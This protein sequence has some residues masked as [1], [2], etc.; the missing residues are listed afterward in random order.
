MFKSD[1]LTINSFT[2]TV[3]T[4]IALNKT[5]YL[6]G[7]DISITCDVTGSPAPE[8]RWYKNDERLVSDERIKVGGKYT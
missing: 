4:N 2:V 6:A 3:Q 7:S 1:N 5:S 8:V